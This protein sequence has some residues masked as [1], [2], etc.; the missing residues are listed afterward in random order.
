MSSSFRISDIAGSVLSAQP[1][2]LNNMA[3]STKAESSAGGGALVITDARHLAASVATDM[4]SP[5]AVYHVS[6]QQYEQAFADSTPRRQ[7][8]GLSFISDSLRSLMTAI[9]D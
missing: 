6:M 2:H 5:D 7:Q 8:A 1:V 3:S 9:I 4:N